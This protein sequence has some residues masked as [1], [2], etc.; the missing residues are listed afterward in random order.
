MAKSGVT[1]HIFKLTLGVMLFW[2]ENV[3]TQAPLA[4]PV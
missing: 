3:Y 4:K 1:L 2:F